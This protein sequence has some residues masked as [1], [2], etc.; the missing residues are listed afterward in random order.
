MD[1]DGKLLP[2]KS[3]TISVRCYESRLGRVNAMVTKVLVD[4]TQVLWSK[5]EE[6]EWE[7]IG[8]LEYP[9]RI[10]VPIKVAGHSTAHFQ[11]YRVW[12]RIEACMSILYFSCGRETEPEHLGVTHMPVA[13]VGTRLFRHFELPF[14][15]YDLPPHPST[16]SSPI[17]YLGSQTSKPR[18]PE[19]RYR[20]SVPTTPVGPQDLVS[21]P[22]SLQPIDPAVSIRSAS[23]IVERRIQLHETIA[24]SSNL[25]PTLPIPIIPPSSQSHPQSHSA[26]SSYSSPAH[27]NS[28]NAMTNGTHLSPY[29]SP[30]SMTPSPS[31]STVWSDD[32]TRPLLSNSPSGLPAFAATDISSKTITQ[33]VA[34]VESSGSFVVDENGVWTKTLTL[35]WP[36]AKSHTRWA[37]GET[38]QSEL[39]AVRFIA[40]VKVRLKIILPVA[41]CLINIYL[42]HCILTIRH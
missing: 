42:D 6:R 33:S 1:N 29:S 30:P 20:L 37:M 31:T 8:D 18:A 27:E 9:F 10:T 26:P 23:L 3:I 4:Y 14:M 16:P 24:S 11:D 25:S 22:I 17:S 40:R 21:V 7:D 36:S 5:A 2:A 28:Y 15:R 19:I 32:T 38:M 35:Q 39:A 41:S 13:G 34:G 12:W